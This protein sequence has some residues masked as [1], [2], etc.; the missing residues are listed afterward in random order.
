[1]D[2]RAEEAQRL[3]WELADPLRPPAPSDR[4]RKQVRMAQLHE[5]MARE[6]IGRGK[7]GGWVDVFAGITAWSD[8]DRPEE[9]HRLIEEGR[10][11]AGSFPDQE[12]GLLKELDDLE[13]WLTTRAGPPRA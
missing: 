6:S 13:A 3:Y 2:P 5:S 9:A 4:I 1:M 11:W 7:F 10:R 8:A 12:Q